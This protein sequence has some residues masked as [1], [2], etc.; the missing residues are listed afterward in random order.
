MLGKRASGTRSGLRRLQDLRWGRQ[1]S[2]LLAYFE[3]VLGYED[4][5]QLYIGVLF[6]SVNEGISG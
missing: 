4:E 5:S 6:S 1:I 3:M 2:S